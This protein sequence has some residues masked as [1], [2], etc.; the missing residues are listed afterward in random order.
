MCCEIFWAL[1]LISFKMFVEKDLFLHL[2]KK[3]YLH[4][5]LTACQHFFVADICGFFVRKFSS[6]E[7]SFLNSCYRCK[8]GLVSQGLRCCLA[9]IHNIHQ[10]YKP[11]LGFVLLSINRD[12][13]L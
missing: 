3:I 7:L 10:E 12:F 4:F 8:F 11:N 9:M 5:S 2:N 13:V 6:P 1:L